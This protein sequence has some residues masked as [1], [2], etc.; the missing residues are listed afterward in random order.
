[1][2][3]IAL[4]GN[5]G[6]GK[7]TVAQLFQS[8]GAEII[9]A[10]DIAKSLTTPHSPVNQAI[11]SHLGETFFNAQ[12][13]LNRAA[14]R[15]HI[16]QVP[17]DRKWLENCLHP[18]IRQAIEATAKASSAPY[19]IAE[20]PLFTSKS[21]YPFIQR[22]LL[23]QADTATQLARVIKRDNCSEAEA[24]ALLALQ[25]TD[26]ERLALADDVIMN[27]GSIDTLLQKVTDY[28]QQYLTIFNLKE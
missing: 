4:T 27:T 1:M 8:L 24:K 22:V 25:P 17:E 7:S 23:V 19:C 28:H 2:S 11:Q 12:G 15:Q 10:D 18:L 9:S 20:I 5:I 16:I 13:E 26:E 21:A 6:S 3:C 14:L